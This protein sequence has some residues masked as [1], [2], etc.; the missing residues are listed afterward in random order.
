MRT[1]VSELRSGSNGRRAHGSKSPRVSIT[2]AWV[3]SRVAAASSPK[4]RVSLPQVPLPVRSVS[5]P[6]GRPPIPVKRSSV[7]QLGQ[8]CGGG[9]SAALV[10]AWLPKRTRIV[11]MARSS[12]LGCLLLGC[13]LLG[14]LLLSHHSLPPSLVIRTRGSMVWRAGFPCETSWTI[15]PAPTSSATQR[16]SS[17]SLFD[18]VSETLAVVRNGPRT[19]VGSVASVVATTSSIA[20]QV[21]LIHRLHPSRQEIAKIFF[22]AISCE[23]LRVR[24]L[25]HVSRPFKRSSTHRMREMRDGVVRGVRRTH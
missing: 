20:I 12:F 25:H 15:S 23:Q 21:V 22:F 1:T 10:S 18:E 19:R 4:A 3:N 9:S 14:C 24:D 5:R 11:L 17:R 7:V 13:W 2:T 16:V 6:R 8:G